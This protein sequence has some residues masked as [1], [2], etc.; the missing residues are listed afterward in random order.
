MPASWLPSAAVLRSSWHTPGLRWWQLVLLAPLLAAVVAEAAP[1]AADSA[2]GAKPAEPAKPAAQTTPASAVAETD[3]AAQAVDDGSVHYEWSTTQP[4]PGERVWLRM[5]YQNTSAEPVQVPA[6][7]LTRA[8]IE[9]DYV[10]PGD[11]R[12]M[13]GR[14]FL[15]MAGPLTPTGSVAWVTLPPDATLERFVDLGAETSACA[16]GCKVGR[17]RVYVWSQSRRWSGATPDQ[18]EP[19]VPHLEHSFAI[20]ARTLPVAGHGA[21]V[22]TLQRVKWQRP[23]VLLGQVRLRNQS[24]L[25]MWVLRPEAGFATCWLR[26][27]VGQEAQTS[28]TLM[29]A[30][31]QSD[32][33]QEE[34]V[35][36]QPGQQVVLPAR[37]EVDAAVAPAGA[38]DV[39]VQFWLSPRSR[40]SPLTAVAV[41]HFW[42]EVL[43][44]T[45]L[46]LPPAP[47]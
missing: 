29:A 1:P 4:A 41:P 35:L 17:Y 31:G 37:C 16:G 18:V 46:P 33:Q 32:W 20:E 40:F 19:L 36:L 28:Q 22:A 6:D 5:S 45:L 24:K 7:L 27:Q 43:L 9:V 14:G 15:H 42:S 38:K 2:Q 26:W 23:G 30:G 11:R 3:P 8:S 34:A 47:R 21:L 10:R 44:S 13:A 12:G 39:S 25:A